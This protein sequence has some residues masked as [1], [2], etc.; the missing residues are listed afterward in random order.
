MSIELNQRTGLSLERL[1]ALVLLDDTG[2]LIRAAE[3]DAGRQSRYSHYLADL[4]SHFGVTLTERVGRS[5]RL[6]S[7]GKELARLARAHLQALG[8]FRK[9]VR[10]VSAPYRLGGRDSL[11][12]WVA[13]PAIAA[14]RRVSR[15]E[16]FELQDLS[17]EDTLARLQE[18]RLDLALLT[19]ETPLSGFKSKVISRVHHI[20]VVPDRFASRGGMLTLSQALLECP[21]AFFSGDRT[22]GSAINDIAASLDRPFIPALQCA[23]ISQCV[24]AVRTGQFAAVLP[25]WSWSSATAV[26]HE[27]WD[28]PELQG[29]DRAL[30]LA[31]HPRLVR[32]RGPAAQE[33][34]GALTKEMSAETATPTL[35]R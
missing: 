5:L 17:P 4:A 15:I 22:L 20:I 2:S 14:L 18:N 34:I 8:D 23:S 33:M 21:H 24:V 35:D 30:V 6:T 28:G 16:R 29:L 26:P 11:L 25:Q 1:E 13:V 10:G 12:Q 7:S 19:N 27:V 32:T 9:N 3:G 31:W